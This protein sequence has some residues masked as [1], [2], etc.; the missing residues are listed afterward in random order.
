MED[1]IKNVTKSSSEVSCP[2]ECLNGGLITGCWS[3]SPPLYCVKI[4]G[5]ALVNGAIN[6]TDRNIFEYKL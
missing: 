6:N 2:F 3:S 5:W 4:V 1:M